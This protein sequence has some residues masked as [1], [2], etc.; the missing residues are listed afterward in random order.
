MDHSS[1]FFHSESVRLLKLASGIFVKCFNFLYFFLY[2]EFFFL[3]STPIDL[4]I[5]QGD[6]FHYTW[7]FD[8]LC[9]NMRQHTYH[10]AA[11]FWA[12]VLFDRHKQKKN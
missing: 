11:M 9:N 6:Q 8:S 10:C 1:F 12:T 2:E 3:Y 4:R 5:I 7:G